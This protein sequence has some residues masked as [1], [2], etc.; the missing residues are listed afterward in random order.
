M[1]KDGVEQ[2]SVRRAVEETVEAGRPV[3]EA[4]TLVQLKRGEVMR[5]RWK[6]GE[7]RDIYKVEPVGF[8]GLWLQGLRGSE[9]SRMT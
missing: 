7:M 2:L 3:V 4:L 9:V 8:S 6:G 1:I 5:Q